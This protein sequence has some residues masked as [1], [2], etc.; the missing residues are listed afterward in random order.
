[1]ADLSAAVI[2]CLR[3]RDMQETI[4]FYE[5]LGFKLTGQY[6]QEGELAWCEVSRGG[7]RIHFHALDHPEMPND[8]IMS[9]VLYFRPDDVMALVEEWTGK[10]E[11]YWGPEIMQYGWREFAFRDPSGYIMAFCEDVPDQ[12]AGKDR[13]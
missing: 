10:V 3:A 6:D 5:N 2:P 7:A 8:P 4:A 11:F 9:G 1:M 12:D 13:S